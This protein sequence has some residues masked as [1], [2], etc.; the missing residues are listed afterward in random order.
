MATTDLEREFVETVS[1]RVVSTLPNVVPHQGL[2][3]EPPQIAGRASPAPPP[4]NGRGGGGGRLAMLFALIASAVFVGRQSPP[5]TS[6][7]Y[8]ASRF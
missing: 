3:P 1:K 2:A 4:P 6:L 8:L 7:Q 5:T